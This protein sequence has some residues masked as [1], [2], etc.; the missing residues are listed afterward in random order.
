[1]GKKT[2]K[3]DRQPETPFR[4]D[5][6]SKPHTPVK[7]KHSQTKEQRRNKPSTLKSKKLPTRNDIYG[8]K[9]NKAEKKHP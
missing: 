1:V 5:K 9:N 7:K 4:Q 2:V 6:Q 3:K 8:R